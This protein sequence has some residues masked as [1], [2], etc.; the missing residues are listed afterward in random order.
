MRYD[1]LVRFGF[2]KGFLDG[3]LGSHTAAMFE[4]YFDDQSKSGLLLFELTQ[5]SELV[6][7]ANHRGFQVGLH[8]IGDAACHLALDAYEWATPL[9][10]SQRSVRRISPPLG[11][12]RRRTAG[13][14][15]RI[16]HAQF[17]HPLDLPRLRGLGVI[18]AIQPCHLM[19]D[20]RIAKGRV[21]RKRC[22]LSGYAWR[23]LNDLGVPIPL[24]TDWPVELPNPFENLYAAVTRKNLDGEPRSGWFPNERLTIE[25]ALRA[26]TR[27]AAFAEFSEGDKGT[28]EP[29]KL[30][31]LV[32]VDRD[33][34]RVAADEVKDARALMTV[35]GGRIIHRG[36]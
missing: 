34:T 35:F 19:T 33:L 3:S 18:V 16:E 9:T 5:L 25:Q 2:L 32:V 12:R 8:A 6:A 20:M 24:G 31:D 26:Y 28:V 30:A 1:A 36:L 10:P 23:T 11:G 14:R 15:N 7:Q 4:P 27:D 29:G 13:M 22:G 17:I 21:G